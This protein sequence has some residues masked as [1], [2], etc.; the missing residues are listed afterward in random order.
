MLTI[1][2]IVSFFTLFFD[3]VQSDKDKPMEKALI[4]SYVLFNTFHFALNF[5]HTP[6]WMYLRAVPSKFFRPILRSNAVSFYKD[7]A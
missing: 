3:R 6:R 7:L 2:S 5:Y 4:I 1:K